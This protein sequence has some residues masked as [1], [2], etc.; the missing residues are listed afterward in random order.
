MTAGHFDEHTAVARGVLKN[1]NNGTWSYNAWLKNQW[2]LYPMDQK[3]LFLK[4]QRLLFL[5]KVELKVLSIHPGG[6]EY[7]DG[8]KSLF[9]GDGIGV[10][11]FKQVKYRIG[12]GGISSSEKKIAFVNL[13]EIRDIK[14]PSTRSSGL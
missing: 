13:R 4:I 11:I 14:F 2:T 12:Y 10:L 3:Y 8:E 5:A 7:Q 1:N 9:N 6:Y